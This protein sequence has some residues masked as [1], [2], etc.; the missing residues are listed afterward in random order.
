MPIYG[1]LARGKGIELSSP[2]QANDSDAVVDV[3][4][5]A[6]GVGKVALWGFGPGLFDIT[7]AYGQSI[8]LAQYLLRVD[9]S[10]ERARLSIVPRY[11]GTNI[12]MLSSRDEQDD[13]SAIII[14]AGELRAPLLV[15]DPTNYN[16]VLQGM[17]MHVATP[18]PIPFE[19]AVPLGA[20]GRS[21]DTSP[22]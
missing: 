1:F 7:P 12:I 3:L 16:L 20:S 11:Q 8:H 21:T 13:E 19:M 17:I 14:E 5:T 2:E 22:N 4:A 10:G 9:H 18:P 15:Q 6:H